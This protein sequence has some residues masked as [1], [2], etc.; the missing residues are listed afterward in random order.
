MGFLSQS[1][2]EKKLEQLTGGLTL[3]DEYKAL[4]RANNIDL[5]TGEHIKKQLKEEIKLD[6]VSADGLETRIR[7]L[8]KQHAKPGA[9]KEPQEVSEPVVTPFKVDDYALKAYLKQIN[10]LKKEYDFKETNV[11]KLIEKRFAPP[12]I[13]YD[14][15]MA[16]V[17]KCNTVFNDQYNSAVSII[18]LASEDSP[19]IDMELE[20]K[21][22]SLK[23]IIKSIDELIGEL[24]INLNSKSDKDVENLSED[25]KD[26]IDSVKD[27][28]N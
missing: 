24:V 5:G 18:N 6:I 25:M 15:F 20:N 19:K 17:N 26:L 4:L 28:D 7:Y 13:T 3:S 11:K 8:I 14:K 10:E 2:A 22:S 21:I 23:S 1:P 16:S 27:Y 9:S 12:Q